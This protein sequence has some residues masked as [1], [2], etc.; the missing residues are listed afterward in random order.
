MQITTVNKNGSTLYGR[1]K[2]VNSNFPLCN[3]ITWWQN[4]YN[5]TR[6]VTMKMYPLDQFGLA[7]YSITDGG[8]VMNDA[9]RQD[10]PVFIDKKGYRCV[11]INDR[12]VRIC[13]MVALV[14]IPNPRNKL[15]VKHVDCIKT[16]DH[17]TNLE[18]TNCQDIDDTNG[19]QKPR[20]MIDA[21]IAHQICQDLER[22]MSVSNVA[23]KFGVSHDLAYSIKIGQRWKD[24]SKH[25][26]IHWKKQNRSKYSDEE[27]RSFCI[28]NRDFNLTPAQISRIYG[29]PRDGIRKILKGKSG[30]DIVEDYF[31]FIDGERYP[32]YDYSDLIDDNDDRGE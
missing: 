26:N 18:W 21:S 13:Q 2:K 8:V 12:E 14:F 15:H 19:I 10:V 22:G 25:Y 7:G 9:T 6:K 5:L 23:E 16:N 30:R 3:I 1:F 31:E 24:V 27:I 32:I 28:M 4:N 29:Y 20:A 17:Y 11:R